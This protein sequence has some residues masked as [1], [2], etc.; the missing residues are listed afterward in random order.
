M[1][2]RLC[3]LLATACLLYPILFMSACGDGRESES[4]VSL[5]FIGRVL[6]GQTKMETLLSRIAMA[7]PARSF[8]GQLQ[9]QEKL[10]R[11]EIPRIGIREW[12]VQG[13]SEGSLKQ[14]AGHIEQTPLPGLGGN[15]TIA[16]DRVLYTSPFL[17]L[18]ALEPGDEIYVEMPYGKF[19]YKVEK[20]FV[21]SKTDVSVLNPQGYDSLTLS[22][23][24]PPWGV[25][26][27][28]TVSARM[29][30]STAGVT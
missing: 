14:G 13:T 23:C 25:E 8:M 27:R 22:T 10:G 9:D 1:G 15:F 29:T 28:I 21:S 4:P 11:I 2:S 16:G 5:D 6:A 3:L 12:I 7:A 26:S 30:E 24:E 19:V 17:R 20:R 18:D